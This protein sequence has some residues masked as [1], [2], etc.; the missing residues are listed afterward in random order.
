MLVKNIAKQVGFRRHLHGEAFDKLPVFL[1]VIAFHHHH[2]VVALL[3]KLL[4]QPEII[5]VIPLVGADQVVLV[6]VRL[7]VAD[8]VNHAHHKQHHLR[9]NKPAGMTK[10]RRCQFAQ[11]SRKSGIGAQRLHTSG[12]VRVHAFTASS[13]KSALEKTSF[14]SSCSS[15]ASIN[16]LTAATSVSAVSGTR[17]VGNDVISAASH[18]MPLASTCLWTAFKIS[19]FGQNFITLRLGLEIFR[20]GFERQFHQLVLARRFPRDNDLP[21]AMKQTAD[22]AGRG[23]AAAVFGHDTANIRRRAV[24]IVRAHFHQQRHAVRPVNLIGQILEVHGLRRRPCPF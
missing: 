21:F 7:Q 1:R 18:L 9:I 12:R 15:N 5:P 20:A 23:D 6:H 2:Q 4:L 8:G 19:R 16:R 24:A 17:R 13:G 3:R 10:H 11:Q 14:T 22:R